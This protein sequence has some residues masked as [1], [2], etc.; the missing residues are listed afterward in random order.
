[1]GATR[2]YNCCSTTKPTTV[3]RARAT[4]RCTGLPNSVRPPGCRVHRGETERNDCELARFRAPHIRIQN[5]DWGAKR[6]LLRHLEPPPQSTGG[7]EGSPPQPK[8][9]VVLC[10]LMRIKM[11][12]QATAWWWRCCSRRAATLQHR[13]RC[14]RR[15]QWSR[16]PP[17]SARSRVQSLT[18]STHP[19]APNDNHP[20][21]DAILRRRW[22]KH[23]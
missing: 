2:W 22:G 11:R 12:M 14:V 21:V 3:V 10:A 15:L 13:T 20:D 23:L 6:T 18:R 7:R 8:T 5:K 1:M 17:N 19:N 9:L 4:P 16:G